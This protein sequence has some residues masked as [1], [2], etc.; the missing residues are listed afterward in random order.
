[1]NDRRPLTRKDVI[2]C[3]VRTLDPLEYVHALWEAGAP[4]YDRV[5]QWSD[6]D[7][8]IVVEDDRIDE[9]LKSVERSLSNLSKIDLKF[10]LPEPTWHGH[11]QAFYRLKET[12]PYLYIDLVAMKRSSKDKFL[13]FQIH[14]VPV[15]Y[16]D[17]TGVVRDDTMD[18]ESFLD[19][20]EKRLETL[21][22]LFA[23][24]QIDILK[25][26]NRGNDLEAHTYYMN[27]TH[28]PLVEALR[29]KYNPFH[30]NFRTHYI[31]YELP[32]EVVKRLHRLTF[33]ADSDELRER[34]VEAEEWFWDT[35]HS[36][37]RNTL[38]SQSQ[39]R[40]RGKSKL[41]AFARKEPSDPTTVIP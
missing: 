38:R 28:R 27:N 40:L 33:I 10:R 41:A 11:S 9:A 26:L 35:V 16:F 34:R 17:K 15:V 14:G 23:M 30:H 8:Y 22:T 19:G 3:L 21:K 36:I 6:I 13:Q 32:A 1:M 24:F 7:L 20:I 25:E 18:L 29:I 12:S 2:A 4:S 31:H 5:D 37:D 39:L